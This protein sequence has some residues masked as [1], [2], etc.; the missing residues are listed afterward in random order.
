VHAWF[1]RFSNLVFGFEVQICGAAWAERG[2]A[3]SA[4]HSDI[5]EAGLAAFGGKVKVND[6]LEQFTYAVHTGYQS[7]A[8][9][10]RSS[11]RPCPL[12]A[13]HSSRVTSA[14]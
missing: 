5:S 6:P 12:R 11:L 8:I 14:P 3:K 1:I 9:H 13:N 2:N 4:P 10:R 7:L